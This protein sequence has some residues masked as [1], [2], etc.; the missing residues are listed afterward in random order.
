MCAAQSYMP[1]IGNTFED[2]VERERGRAK[3]Q[4]GG[5]NWDVEEER[6]HYRERKELD[7]WLGRE[8]LVKRIEHNLARVRRG[9]GLP[10]VVFKRPKVE[11]R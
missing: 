6:R 3:T 8:L 5:E 11:G 2:E 10:P 4:G 1:Q 9:A 7:R